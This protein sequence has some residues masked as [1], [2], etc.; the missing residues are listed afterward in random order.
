MRIALA[1]DGDNVS[2]HFGHCE[3]F[4][5]YTVEDKNIVEVETIQNPGHKK[6]F[7]PGFLNDHGVNVIISGGMGQGAIE[8]FKENDI[9]V[10]TG[11]TGDLDDVVKAYIDGELESTGSVCHEHEHKD[12]CH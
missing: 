8:L 12:S 10:I 3:A 11:A 1:T 9:E 4:T 5:V 6:G 7:L 2:K